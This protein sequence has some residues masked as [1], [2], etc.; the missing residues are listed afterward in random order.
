MSFFK[1]LRAEFIDIIEYANTAQDTIVYRFERHGNEIKNNAKLIVREGQTAVFINEGQLADVFSPGTYTLNTEN[2]PI[3]STLKGW[4]YGFNSP[5][6]AEV[7]FVSTK[8]FI[9]QKWGTKSPLIL[10]DNRFGMVEVRAFGIYT[11]KITDPGMFIREIVGTQQTFAT[12]DIESQL[13]S[14]IVTRFTDAVGESNMPIEAY[15][16]NLNE[17]SSTIFGFMKD[18]FAVYGMDITKFLIENVS[19]PDDIKKE[20]FELS[21]LNVVDLDKL[22]KLKAAKAI[23]AAAENPSGTAGMGMGLGAG[24]AMAQQMMQGMNNTAQSTNAPANDTPPPVPTETQYYVAVGGKQTGPYNMQM[25]E[26]LAGEQ[27]LTRDS[28][29]W[30]KGLTEW[31]KASNIDELQTLWAST[32]PPLK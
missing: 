2:L 18:D 11:F 20:I 12:Q 22:T 7:Y 25:M 15:A 21:R 17:L 6:K 1:K 10:N 29:T 13:K 24:M 5:F 16:S 3:L 14:I 27:I 32:P 26:K 9:D 4:K 31:V 8:N 23:E 19:M 30:K 28:L